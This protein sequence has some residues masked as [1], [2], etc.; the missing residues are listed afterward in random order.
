MSKTFTPYTATAFHRWAFNSNEWTRTEEQ[1]NC[2]VALS[3]LR[4]FRQFQRCSDRFIE[5]SALRRSIF[6][7]TVPPVPGTITSTIPMSNDSIVRRWWIGYRTTNGNG[8]SIGM[9]RRSR[10][11][12]RIEI[13]NRST[14]IGSKSL[15]FSLSVA[16]SID[17][18]LV[19]MA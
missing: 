8:K 13:D 10:E 2:S 5:S 19:S 16:F 3:W 4:Q 14:L 17:L 11:N 1:T 7:A 6:L 12:N 9:P 18:V 15:N